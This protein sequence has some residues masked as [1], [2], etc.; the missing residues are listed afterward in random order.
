MQLYIL[1]FLSQPSSLSIS[2]SF[3]ASDWL[4]FSSLVPPFPFF[5]FLPHTEEW[6]RFVPPAL[7]RDEWNLG[8][9]EAGAG[10][11]PHPWPHEGREAAHHS[12]IG[13]GQR[14]STGI[15][16]LFPQ[17]QSIWL[18]ILFACYLIN[19]FFLRLF[20]FKFRNIGFYHWKLFMYKNQMEDILGVFWR[21]GYAVAKSPTLWCMHWKSDIR[22]VQAGCWIDRPFDVKWYK[23]HVPMFA[24]WWQFPPHKLSQGTRNLLR[25]SEVFW[26]EEQRF[27]SSTTDLWHTQRGPCSEGAVLSDSTRATEAELA[28]V[29]AGSWSN[30][31]NVHL[32]FA[33]IVRSGCHWHHEDEG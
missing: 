2:L 29:H 5:F 6:G 9:E 24:H 12:E 1:I 33:H 23:I 32:H 11:P 4:S 14:V 25:N 28:A 17:V 16:R 19:N 18:L 27:S 21:H 26:L 22:D 30:K 20:N 8:P 3:T 10:G 7:A 13:L 31:T 15:R